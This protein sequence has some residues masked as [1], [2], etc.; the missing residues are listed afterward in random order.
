MLELCDGT[1]KDVI[2]GK[3]EGAPLPSKLEVLYQI[4]KGLDYIHEKNI[5]HRDVKP[6]NILIS[7]HSVIKLSDFGFCKKLDAESS[8]S[9]SGV[10]GTL[11]WTAPELQDFN[12][13]TEEPKTKATKASDIFATGLVFFV[14]LSKGIHPFGDMRSQLMQIPI[15]IKQNTQIFGKLPYITVKPTIL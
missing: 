15:N 10:K 11:I 5:I 13:E 14:F 4:A 9:V 3:Y 7:K 8:S 6:P 2:D 12:Y 1:L